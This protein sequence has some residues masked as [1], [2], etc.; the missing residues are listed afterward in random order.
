MDELE[1]KTT[2]SL[3]V[4]QVFAGIVSDNFRVNISAAKILRQKYPKLFTPG[5]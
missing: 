5:C 4:E 2:A 3:G 1:K